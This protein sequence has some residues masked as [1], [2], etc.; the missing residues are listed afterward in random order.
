VLSSPRNAAAITSRGCSSKSQR[1]Q[2]IST[3]SN[4]T[5]DAIYELTQVAQGSS[6]TESYTYDP[7]GNRLSSLG[8][9]S[10]TNNTSNEL[11]STSNATYTYDYN[12]NLLAKVVGSNTTSFAWDYENRLTSVTSIFAYDGNNLV[13]E[14]NASGTAVARYSQGLN[15]DEP[16]AMLRGGATSFYHADGLG[17][18]TSLSNSSGSIA[19]TYTFDS[20]GNQTASSGSLTNPFQYTGREFDSET[21]LYYYRARYYDQTVGRFLRED[22]LRFEG[23]VNF[24]RFVYNSPIGLDDPMGLSA[25]DVKRI[26]ARCSKCTQGLTNDGKRLPG[27]GGWTGFRND[28]QVLVGFLKGLLN[29]LRHGR[30]DLGG[31]GNLQGCKSQAGQTKEC[32]ESNNSSSFDSNWTFSEVPWWFGFHTVVVA[33]SSDTNDPLVF[34]D[35][36]RDGTW[37]DLPFEKRPDFPASFK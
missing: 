11:T 31:S 32:L 29:G 21:S 5:Y 13:E 2:E 10:Y 28:N 4:Y 26:Q 24:Y 17:S 8:V 6:T 3:A 36:W 30:L 7:V 23:D 12:G 14:T 22:P 19:Q 1:Q 35:P 20:F 9:S 37:T 25:A 16:L 34:C 15:I 18:I 33:T 27:S